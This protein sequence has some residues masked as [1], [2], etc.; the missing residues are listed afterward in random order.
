MKYKIGIIVT[1]IACLSLTIAVLYCGTH[2]HSSPSP[3]RLYT[4]M[5]ISRDGTVVQ[6][7]E[8]VTLYRVG[9][10]WCIAERLDGKQ[11]QID[12]PHIWIEE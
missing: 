4:L 3:R 9:V 2:L 7:W 6:K 11:V 8:H 10:G 5:A 1:V 12:G